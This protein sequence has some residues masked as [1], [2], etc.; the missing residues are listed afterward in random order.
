[1]RSSYD[2]SDEEWDIQEEEEMAMLWAMHAKKRPNHGGSV[3]GRQKLWRDRIEGHEKLMHSYFAKN[4][5]FLESYFR[6]C[7]RKSINLFKRIAE[8]F[9]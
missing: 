4:A 3:L 8:E 5:T 1:L 9:K 2:S 6:R 7:F